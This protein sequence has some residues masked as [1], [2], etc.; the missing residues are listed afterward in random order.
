MDDANSNGISRAALQGTALRESVVRLGHGDEIR[1]A[2]ELERSRKETLSGV[3]PNED[4]WVFAYG[5]L[6]WNPIFGV[7]ERRTA[8]LS[9]F[10]RSFCLE[11]TF[12][13]GSSSNPGL[14]LALDIGGSCDG[15]ALKLHRMGRNAELQLLWR[16]EMLTFSYRPLWIMAHSALGPIR[17]LPFVANRSAKNYLGRLPDVDA[18][19]RIASAAGLLGSNLDYLQSTHAGL[20]EHG[21][22][23]PYLSSLL[24][25]CQE[26]AMSPL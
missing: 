26:E 9:G 10:H 16:R 6:I 2:A 3:A 4:L 23:D 14:M 12:G 13:R 15:V 11:S 1:S 17:A 5:S 21:I 7:A 8:S 19:S 18:A 20:A 25:L 22:E 24:S